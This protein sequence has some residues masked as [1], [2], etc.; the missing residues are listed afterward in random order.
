MI[1]AYALD[2]V[3]HHTKKEQELTFL[4]S[5][6]KRQTEFLSKRQK[7]FSSS[8][9]YRGDGKEDFRRRHQT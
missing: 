7:Y 5:N 4:L 3:I 9:V 1:N 8:E 2:S 6:V